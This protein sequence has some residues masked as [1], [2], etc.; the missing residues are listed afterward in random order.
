M[1]TTVGFWLLLL[2]SLVVAA[3]DT[4]SY[5][6]PSYRC[7]RAMDIRYPFWVGGGDDMGSVANASHCGYPSLRLE[8]RRGTPVG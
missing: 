1:S 7:G 3:S 2:S 8:C 5:I 4:T 6:C